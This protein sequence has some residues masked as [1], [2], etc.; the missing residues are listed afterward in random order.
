MMHGSLNVI[1]SLILY[2]HLRLGLSSGSVLNFYPTNT[3]HAF[4]FPLYVLRTPPILSSFNCVPELCLETINNREVP[5][6]E[7]LSSLLSLP[8]YQAQ[9]FYSVP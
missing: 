6:Y 3:L 9:T 5:L 4:L 8:N 7:I 2:S 1:S